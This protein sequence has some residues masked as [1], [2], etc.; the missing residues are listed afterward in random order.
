VSVPREPFILQVA[1]AAVH[2]GAG[3]VLQ[4]Y[5]KLKQSGQQNLPPIV[6][7][8]METHRLSSQFKGEIDV[9]NGPIIR[10][11][12]PALGLQE[13]VDVVFLGFVTEGQLRYLYERCCLVVNAA[14][15]DNGSFSLIEATY[16]GKPV[17]SSRYPAAEFICQRFGVQAK[18][19]PIEDSHALAE[20][21]RQSLAEDAKSIPDQDIADIRRRLA[22]PELSTRRY[23][24]RFYDC[25]AEL[26]KEGR[27]NRLSEPVRSKAAQRHI[28]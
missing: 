26:A 19:F 23:A 4:A 6:C 27:R 28:V 16:F 9:P 10:A 2:K 13:G 7:C 25:L 12:V 21:L 5:A 11:L 15:Y 1:N 18:F 24:E 17:I 14:K 22:D 3:I 8:G 20:I